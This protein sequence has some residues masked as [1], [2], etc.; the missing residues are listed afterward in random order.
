MEQR[1]QQHRRYFKQAVPLRK[2]AKGT[3]PGFA[4]EQLIQRALQA[5]TAAHMQAWLASPGLLPPRSCR[6]ACASPG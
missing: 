5:E 6:P 1:M 4:S 2:E 3:A